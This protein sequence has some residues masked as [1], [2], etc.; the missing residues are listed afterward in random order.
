MGGLYNNI[1]R[2]YKRLEQYEKAIN[3]LNRSL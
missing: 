3:Y 2:V 1:G